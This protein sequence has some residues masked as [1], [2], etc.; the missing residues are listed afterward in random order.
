VV[1]IP[2][3]DLEEKSNEISDGTEHL[4]QELSDTDK[5]NQPPSEVPSDT[6]VP[7][8]TPNPERIS[9]NERIS[10]KVPENT[11]AASSGR[12]SE[13]GLAGAPKVSANEAHLGITTREIG[14]ND[15]TSYRV[16]FQK[17]NQVISPWHDIP[18]Y[19]NK[20]NKTVN[21]ICEIPKGTKKKFEISRTMVNNPIVQ[22]IET[23]SEGNKVLRS[24]KW[25]VDNPQMSWNYGALPQTWED[26]NH[27][28]AD[29]TINGD[30]HP[31]G[32]NDPID[33][34]EIGATAMKTG[35]IAPVKILGVLALVD[36]NET[37]WKLLV[38]R[39]DNPEFQEINT[40]E[41]LKA[42][43][44]GDVIGKIHYWLQNYK[45]PVGKPVNQFGFDGK[46]QD[47][48]Y[49][50]QKVTETHEAWAKNTNSGKINRELLE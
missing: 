32:D 21:F 31:L 49:A 44:Y 41:D 15:T 36:S 37:D 11:P 30:Q 2:A 25:P 10:V 20:E 23:D 22:D 33:A 28:E 47:E 4:A 48:K 9:V 3:K 13:A 43:E 27:P 38:V 5:E 35:E 16:E 34:I 7:E 1:K 29:I 42:S 45:T 40:L 17:D 19:H 18:L 8:N 12:V 6:P 14:E 46:P 26:P 39:V 24:Y 50:L